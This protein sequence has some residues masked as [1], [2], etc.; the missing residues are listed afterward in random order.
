MWQILSDAICLSLH[1]AFGFIFAI[2]ANMRVIAAAMTNKTVG[3]IE[4]TM[5]VLLALVAAKRVRNELVD[6]H[7]SEACFDFLR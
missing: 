5:P 6:L 7:N 4:R 3:A 1:D 2:A